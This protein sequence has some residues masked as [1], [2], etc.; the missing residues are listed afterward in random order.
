M[1][2]VTGGTGYIGSHTAVE[3]LSAG[4]DVVLLDNLSNSNA[5]VVDR[6]AAISGKKVP[7]F[8]GDVCLPETIL[9]IEQVYGI[10]DAIIH[11]AAY[12]AVGESMEH[13]LRYFRNNID[14]LLT[15]LE[16]AL[17]WPSCRG[18]VLSSSCTVYGSP[19]QLPVSEESPILPAASPY[20][21]TK[22][23][24]EEMLRAAC[25]ASNIQAISLRYFNPIGA[26][27]SALIGELP[28]GVPSN[29][30][31]FI[32]QS[33]IGKRGPLQVFGNDYH[34]P[35]GTCIRD[36]IHVV[37]LARAHVAAVERLLDGK[38]TK[39][40]EVFNVGTGKGF[41]VMEVIHAFERVNGVSLP[42]FIGPRRPGDVEQIWANPTRIEK[43]MGWRA[44]HNLD[45]MVKS[46]WNWEKALKSQQ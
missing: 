25:A 1:I 26:H 6:I 7:L 9:N 13:P 21:Y 27:P 36:F 29:L 19:N 17:I 44:S 22:Q 38:A 40:F 8:V 33:A 39:G 46:A 24:C 32:T 3:L 31:P 45:D 30:M 20:G 14:G 28:N 23:V 42:F 2:L 5:D 10:P 37:D 34:T 4:Y 35:D 18:I 41:S 16:K 15:P 11:F 12:K 43:E